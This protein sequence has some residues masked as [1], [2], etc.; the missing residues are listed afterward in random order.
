MNQLVRLVM[1][2]TFPIALGRAL[3]E[4]RERTGASQHEIAERLGITLEYYGRLERGQQ[5]PSLPTLVDLCRTLDVSFDAL[6]RET[7]ATALGAREHE[8]P[9]GALPPAKRRL[10]RRIEDASPR[11]VRLLQLLAA[12]LAR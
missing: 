6:V 2:K 5:L 7:P 3:R 4:G 10:I 9:Y 11:T 8:K 1:K 12:E